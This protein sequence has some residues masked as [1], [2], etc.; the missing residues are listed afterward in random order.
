MGAP[1]DEPVGCD[2]GAQLGRRGGELLAQV[3]PWPELRHRRLTRADRVRF[4]R[5]G[6]PAGEH[7]LAGLGARVAHQVEQRAVPEQVEVGGVRVIGRQRSRRASGR[8]RARPRRAGRGRARSSAP[9]RA[10]ARA[11][12]DAPVPQDQRDEGEQ[13]QQQRDR[14]QRGA[15][16]HQPRQRE[17]GDEGG[18]PGARQARGARCSATARLARRAASRAWY[19]AG[20]PGRRPEPPARSD[21]SSR[22]RRHRP[23]R[24]APPRTQRAERR[25]R[26]HLGDVRRELRPAC[27]IDAVRRRA[28]GW[29]SCVAIAMS[30]IEKCAA[31]DA[32]PPSPRAGPRGSRTAAAAP[33]RPPSRPWR[34]RRRGRRSAGRRPSG[35]RSSRPITATMPE[36][37][38]SSNH[39]APAVGVRVGWGRARCC[40]YLRSR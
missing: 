10:S 17:A 22:V 6:E 19:S 2:L 37:A 30:A 9:H 20:W 8:C 28:A 27:R 34:R 1:R 36:S 35:R 7:A 11:R 40:G 24:R 12:A 3:E 23:S 38:Y 39:S 15:V 26:V 21:R 13:R 29:R 32:S 33:R 14:R 31:D 5:R 25:T 16:E 18:E 4:G